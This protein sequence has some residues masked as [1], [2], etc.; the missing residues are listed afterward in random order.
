MSQ[1]PLLGVQDMRLRQAD[2][3]ESAVLA[4]GGALRTALRE[5]AQVR[6][7]HLQ[8]ALPPRRRVRRCHVSLLSAVW[9]GTKV[10]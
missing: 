3:P 10:M 7:S 6:D 1:V 8:E 5:K 9:E 4:D 2:A